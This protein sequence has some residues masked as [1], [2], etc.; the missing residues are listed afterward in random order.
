[1]GDIQDLLREISR[2]DPR[3]FPGNP[4]MLDELHAQVL[5]GVDKLELQLR[6]EM[7]DKHAGQVRTGEA[8]HV[9]AGYEDSVADYFRRLSNKSEA[10]R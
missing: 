2:L 10:V 6:R 7:D 8:R 3:R 9:P 4:A 5:A 1:L